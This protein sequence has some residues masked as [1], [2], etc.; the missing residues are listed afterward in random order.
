MSESV[1]T[2]AG[3]GGVPCVCME[4]NERLRSTSSTHRPFAISERTATPGSGLGGGMDDDRPFAP[5]NLS[6][7]AMVML[8][9]INRWSGHRRLNKGYAGYRWS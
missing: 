5:E 4:R 7:M 6:E 9:P 2:F 3:P 1:K 8:E